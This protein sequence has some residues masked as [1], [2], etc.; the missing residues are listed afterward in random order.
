[1]SRHNPAAIAP[2]CA[3][4]AGAIGAALGAAVLA[5]W[6]LGVS[7][8]SFA[9]GWLRM[10]PLA[11]ATFALCGIALVLAA[12][13]LRGPAHSRARRR[14]ALACSGLAVL[15]ALLR[16]SEHVF[17]WPPGLDGL[18][19]ASALTAQG[20]AGGSMR[21][22]TAIGVALL[23]GALMLAPA[24]RW[25][26]TYQALAVLAFLIAAQ[27]LARHLF[28][29]MPL[30]PFT[31]MGVY[32][33]SALL[34]LT[35]GALALRED[36]DLARLLKDPGLGGH[37]ARRLLPAAVVA[38]FAVGTLALYAERAGLLQTEQTFALVALMSM[39]VLAGL[40][41]INAARIRG[42]EVEQRRAQA[43]LGAS[44]QLLRGIVEFSDDAIITTTLGGMITSWNPGAERL[45]GHSARHAVGQSMQLLIP[46]DR[47]QEE[48]T[49]L[50]RIARGRVV[51]HFETVRLRGDHT[52]VEI[53]AT[54]SPLKD[55]SGR[56]VG[57]ST[58]ARDITQRKLQ[59]RRLQAQV[60]RLS[61]LEQITRAISDSQD[62]PSILHVLVTTL[63][64]RL[65]LDFA[66]I[67][68]YRPPG[69][70]ALS[71]VAP[72]SGV[73]AE[74]LAL[75][76]Q[77]R[78]PIDHNGLSR[79]ILGQLVHEPDVLEAPFPFSERFARSGL[80]SLV[81][82]PL[83]VQNQPFGVLVAARKRPQAFSSGD[84]EF[85]RQATEHAALAAQQ[86][87]LHGALQSAYED[88][89]RTQQ[90]VMQHERLRVLGT[91]A[92]G[93]AH[94]INNAIS[95]VTLYTE[96][97]LESGAELDERTRDYLKI[98]ERAVGDVA[99]TIARMREFYREREPQSELRPLQ[100]NDLLRQVVDLTRARWSDM[101]LRR[102][103]VI[104]I[105]TDLAEDI[106][107]VP[108]IESELREAFTNLV[109]NAVDAMP[110]GGRITLRSRF[111]AQGSN[112]AG[113]PASPSVHVEVV[114]SGIGMDQ[115][116]RLHCLEPFFTTKG[117][118]GTGLGLAMVYGTVERHGAQIDIQ[119]EPG[120]GTTVRLRFHLPRPDAP[121]AAQTGL[122]PLRPPPLR[123]LLVDDDVVLTKS[124]R[125]AL[126]ADG[127]GVTVA[128]GGRDG[129]EAFR[130]AP[131][132]GE[133][134]DV[135]ITDLGMP[136]VDGRRVASAVKVS[137]PAT[138]VVLLTGWGHRLIADGEAV[139]HVDRVLSKP[140]TL[141]QLRA[142]L[143]E[144]TQASDRGDA[145]SRAALAPRARR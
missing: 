82:V 93:I 83:L 38:P 116:T 104:E 41:W 92:S 62:L 68:L 88:L 119:S 59:E 65:P 5:G 84:C 120:R 15:G 95:P 107:E 131:A 43:A 77:A 136:H 71:C 51:D 103:I 110:E 144:L 42:M 139:P 37:S 63:E 114:D 126:A 12:D 90:A 50:E 32:T 127:H 35:L 20:T 69:E 8:L 145:A 58:I 97:L 89:R 55:A 78:V 36:T 64:D 45:F 1:M 21:P 48:S 99:E 4:A 53:S 115:T 121:R 128:N 24:V 80:R 87:E 125:D 17:G 33:S 23:G 140:A 122:V 91:M 25:S 10:A 44:Q 52:P 94:D 19:L 74:Q 22:A 137:S 75:S 105:A 108:G 14:A 47:S 6:A 79:C 118:R 113:I 123:I 34:V 143:C 102:G 138:P 30:L 16:L 134:F 11:A 66:C 96:M 106:P 18:G 73:L 98:I 142:V 60:E 7:T 54:I 135:V 2:T 111:D 67:C 39:L 117:E 27:G 76:Q 40:I 112:V 130:A 9:P 49:I 124:L 26:R 70:L 129:I 132:R 3:A 85:L 109:V 61:L 101:P 46:P 57:A 141:A 133:D 56:V 100:L 28:G 81:M 72:R 29:G 13:D 31:R 86:A